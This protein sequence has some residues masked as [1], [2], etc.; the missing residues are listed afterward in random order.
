ML[1]QRSIDAMDA[2]VLDAADIE[3]LLSPE[4]AGTG[5]LAVTEKIAAAYAEKGFEG[6]EHQ[7]AEQIFRLLVRDAE[8]N[9]RVLMAQTLK[10]ST[11]LPHD[12]VMVMARD[13]EEVALPVLKHSEVLNE[14]D[15]IQLVRETGAVTRHEAVA[16]RRMIPE[17]LSDTLV[18]TGSERVL[19]SLIA[20]QGAMLSEKTLD[21]VV[22]RHAGEPSLMQALAKRDNLPLTVAEK[23]ITHVSGALAE[24]L[25]RK[26]RMAP[27][28]LKPEE[29][30]TRESATLALVK[31]A[32][33]PEEMDRLAYQL[34]TFRRLTPSLLIES[35]LDGYAAFFERCMAV[36]AGVPHANARKLLL[37]K[38]ELGFQALCARAGLPDS[39]HTPLKKLYANVAELQASAEGGAAFRDALL[40]K[41]RAEAAI[42]GQQDVLTLAGS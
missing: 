10:S 17:A 22:A 13:V 27:E 29:E 35:L 31:M 14:A 3:L 18:E 7:V 38:G 37:D 32:V 12:I 8:L 2:L 4:K 1:A 42:T 26:Y 5:R 34:L 20:N 21:E 28:A 41:L 15:L 6:G 24:T 16:G 19:T 39:M 30:K 40:Q 23:L 11:R 9:I 33:S 25:Q 36:L